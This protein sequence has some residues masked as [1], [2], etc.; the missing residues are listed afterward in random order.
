MRHQRAGVLFAVSVLTATTAALTSLAAQNGRSAP[1]PTIPKTWDDTAIASLQLTLAQVK[2]SPIPLSS[3]YYYRIPV[4]PL[5]K[6]YPV[7]HPD[8]E[9]SGYFERLRGAEP[10]M[11][12]FD[13]SNVTSNEEWIRLGELVFDAPNDYDIAGSPTQFRDSSYYTALGIPVA[14]DGTVPFV[15]YVVRYRGK[16]EVGVLACGPCHTRVTSDGRVTTAAPGKCP[17]DRTGPPDMPDEALPD[18]R[19]LFTMLYGAPWLG[20]RDP[21]RP[22]ATMSYREMLEYGRAIPPGVQVR[23]GTSYPN[24]AQM[25]DLIGVRERRYLDH[26]G[27]V[28]HRD[29][30]DVMRYAALNQSADVY[31][32]YGDFL[33]VAEDLRTLPDPYRDSPFV[34]A[35]G[36]YSDEQLYA[37]ATFLY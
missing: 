31:S 19:R 33:P 18:L 29:I 17:V 8:K 11:L 22:F 30:G 10:E 14:R 28:R 21:A 16:V 36:R 34:F 25:P 1:L 15:R 24:P 6:T 23:H 32:R 13:V 20:D 26:T 35:N 37:L 3:D 27:L 12:S 5:F 9:P 2:R 7:Y 4:R